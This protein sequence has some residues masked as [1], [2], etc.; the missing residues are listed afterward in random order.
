MTMI[1]AVA[2]PDEII[3][4]SDSRVSFSKKN[5]QLSSEDRLKKI[6]Q[7]NSHVV[8]AFT[9]ENVGLTWKVIEKMTIK[10]KD[11]SGLSNSEF[12]KEITKIA[13]SEYK[14]IDKSGTLME[15]I[16]A[17]LDFK[18]KLKVESRKLETVLKKCQEHS[19]FPEKLVDIKLLEKKFTFIPAPSPILVKQTFPSG[20]AIFTKGWN[21][22]TAGSGKSFVKELEKFYPKIF[23]FPGAFNKGMVIKDLADA[24][25]E[26]EEIKSVGGIVQL[27]AITSS[28]V[29]PIQFAQ[30]KN[31]KA[32]IKR[33]VDE[34]GNWVEENLETNKK[35]VVVQN[36]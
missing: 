33:Y 26:R 32:I 13:K 6:Y 30:T 15:F 27:F 11:L 12:L 20:E 35:L 16:Y 22:G 36:L 17:G 1:A 21:M 34:N 9:S 3:V 2:F 24:Y 14:S 25:I 8:F 19:Y 28:G 18:S 4:L 31:G 5:I 23:F 7:L 29:E 10:L